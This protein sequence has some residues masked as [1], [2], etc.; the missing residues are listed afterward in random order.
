MSCEAAAGLQIVDDEG[1]SGIEE[2]VPILLGVLDCPVVLGAA[3]GTVNGD[4]HPSGEH[5]VDLLMIEVATVI[6][7]D[8]QGSAIFAE[9]FFQVGGNLFTTGHITG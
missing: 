4:D 5:I 1:I 7:L 8:E 3:D 2:A 6:A 9:E